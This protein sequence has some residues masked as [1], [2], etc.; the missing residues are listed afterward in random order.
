M[1][2]VC[3]R[4]PPTPP[5]SRG[6]NNCPSQ[7]DSSV[8]FCVHPVFSL[9]TKHTEQDRKYTTLCA[10]VY[11]LCSPC[12]QNTQNRIRSTQR[13]TQSRSGPVRHAGPALCASCVRPVF[14]LCTE[15]TE[16]DPEY[17]EIQNRI[18]VRAVY[19]LCTS[20]VLL[21]Y[22]AHRTGS[23]VHRGVHRAG[24]GRSGM[25]DWLCVLPV[26]VLCSPCV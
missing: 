21:V 2:D 17:T 26:Y 6:V 19:V 4:Q 11:V 9:C 13:S 18:C 25:P 23:G 7:R 15:H 5:E 8:C 3:V 10:S 20:C 14:S 22:R 16:Q 12:V 24:P 1:K